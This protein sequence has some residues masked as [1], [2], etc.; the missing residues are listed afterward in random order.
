MTGSKYYSAFFNMTFADPFYVRL[1][2][3]FYGLLRFGLLLVLIRRISS[4]RS[5]RMNPPGNYRQEAI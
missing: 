3:V 2:G 5:D 1:S 4:D